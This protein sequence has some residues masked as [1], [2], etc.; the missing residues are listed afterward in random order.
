MKTLI[1]L[2]S[3]LLFVLF[4]FVVVSADPIVVSGGPDNDYES[5]ISALSDG[6][7]MIVFDR[8][9]DWQSGDLY[10]TFS[11][12]DG[13]SWSTPT[14]AIADSAD[15]ATLCFIQM[16]GDTIKLWYASNETGNYRIYSAY[17]MDGSNWVKKGMI[18]LG[19][20][21]SYNYYDPTVIMEGDSSL[22]MSYVVSGLGVFISHKP[23][24]G[25]WDTLRTMV[26]SSGFRARVM[27]HSNGT[28]L[29]TYHR[30]SDSGQY[31]YDVFVRT[32]TDR[33]N[34]DEEIRLTDNKNSHDPFPNEA[35][36][37]AYIIYYAKYET[38]SY[39]LYRRISYDAV[40]WGN[41]E[42][43]TF[44]NVNNTQPHFF[45]RSN[46]IYLVWAHAVNYPSDHDVYFEKT[47]YLSEVREP[48]ASVKPEGNLNV[49]IHPNPSNPSTLI[50]YTLP[51][52]AEVSINIYDILGRLAVTLINQNQ[53]AGYHSI[54]WNGKTV[55]N[56]KLP[57]GVYLINIVAGGIKETEK[58][59][60]LR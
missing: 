34:W 55:N 29:Y 32:S 37:G 5:W 26:Y 8:N 43:I 50:S 16:P 3:L 22:T 52:P 24:G 28:Y 39:N 17:S 59:L 36:D 11:V 25:Q 45:I 56:K 58:V 13:N 27:K 21:S 60:I 20:E 46:N 1:H 10:S 19:W 35:P 6:R 53:S 23:Y 40:N 30:R 54:L 33:V 4:L 44:D 51:N 18:E 7:L 41:E 57:S 38:P 2:F 48:D 9:P 31:D 47:P 42:Q 14:V 49:N 12:D 15:Q